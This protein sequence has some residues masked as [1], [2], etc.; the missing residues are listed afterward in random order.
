MFAHHALLDVGENRK[1]LPRRVVFE[2]EE[3]VVVWYA[4]QS[5]QA[6]GVV[7]QGVRCHQS[8]AVRVDDR[9]RT[10]ADMLRA[11]ESQIVVR[12]ALLLEDALQDGL[13]VQDGFRVRHRY[14]AWRPSAPAPPA[15]TLPPSSN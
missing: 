14:D 5:Q 7:S 15:F 9:T 1:P 12:E 6:L 10:R 11:K 3:V 13:R 2:A 8:V 4:V